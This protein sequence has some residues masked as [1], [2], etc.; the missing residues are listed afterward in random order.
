MQKK[1]LSYL[2]PAIVSVLFGVLNALS[3]K[4]FI[5][6]NE[7]ASSG[8]E[9]ISVMI[10]RLT[11]FNLAY[12]QLIFNLPLCIFAFFFID[13]K[14]AVFTVV[15]S[16]TYSV[17]YLLF[18]MSDFLARF[19]Y[20]ALGQ[21]TIYPVL[22]AGVI[23]GAA[24]GFLFKENSSSGGVDILS[25]Y[26]NKRNPRFNF[27]YITFAINAAIA[28]ASYFVFTTEIDG[29]IVYS[30]KPVCMCVLCDFISNFIGNLIIKGRESAYRFFVISDDVGEI[31]KEIAQNL[32]HTSTRFE[33]YGSYT[34][35]K[36][37][38]LMC[39]VTREEIVEFEKILKQH[40][41]CFA[42][43]MT[44]NKVIGYFDKK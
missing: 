26:I 4:L 30:Y 12:I 5:V 2:K 16:V 29:Q 32:I 33:C 8:V 19:E 41:D 39:I 25:R 36:K 18:G 14:F 34:N 13:R 27:F 9:G 28:I 38:G 1:L 20:N 43:E 6:P 22:I 21:D 15:Y 24:Y 11:D 35:E 44:V 10:N 7:F 31:E 37:G 17:A 23:S 3:C 42:Y 40:P